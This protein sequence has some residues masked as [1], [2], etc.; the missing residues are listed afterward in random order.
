[1]EEHATHRLI[2]QSYFT[3]MYAIK[4]INKHCIHNGRVPMSLVLV[5]SVLERNGPPAGPAPQPGARNRST[6]EH[7][8]ILNQVCIISKTNCRPC[9]FF[10][11]SLSVF[12]SQSVPVIRSVV[13]TCG[14][15]DGQTDG[16]RDRQTRGQ[17]ES[18]LAAW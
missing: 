11:P 3:H 13:A 17:Q 8:G 6:Q 4:N 12:S 16:R 9:V 5:S 2:T 15:T 7:L 1:M 18:T 10:C 14:R